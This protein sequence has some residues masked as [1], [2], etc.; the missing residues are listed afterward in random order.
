MPLTARK[1]LNRPFELRIGACRVA[2]IEGNLDRR[3]NADPFQALPVY[4]DV[5]D[6]EQ[7]QPVAADQERCGRE[8]SAFRPL[9]DELTAAEAQLSAQT[10]AAI[11]E[12]VRL[13]LIAALQARHAR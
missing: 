5:L 9:A 4:Q 13:A 7:Q 1:D 2:Q 11:V 8:H 12:Q 10:P 3:L 6:R